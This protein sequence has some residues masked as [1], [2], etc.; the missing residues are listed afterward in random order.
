MGGGKGERLFK[1]GAG[2]ARWGGP[3][4]SGVEVQGGAFQ[5]QPAVLSEQ[6]LQ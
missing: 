5:K 1:G 4:S 2:A 6:E 3:S